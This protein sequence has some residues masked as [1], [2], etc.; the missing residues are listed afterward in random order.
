VDVNQAYEL[1]QYCV[2]KN[3]AQGYLSPQDFNH[4]INVAQRSYIDY[5]IGQYQQYQAKRPI[6]IVAFGENERVRT[7]LA[8][9]IYEVVIPVNSTT[10][11]GAFP[12][13]FIQVDAMWGQYGFYNIRFTEQVRLSANYRSVIDSPISNNDNAVYLIRH[14]G[15]KFFPE[16]IGNA[17]CS[18][19]QN[20]PSISWGYTEVNGIPVWNPATSSNP[21]WDDTDLLNIIVRALA[22]VGVNLQL[23]VVQ[24]YSQTI[25]TQGQ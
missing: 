11:I 12:Y 17:R 18:Y 8:P 7:S 1:C 4:V 5:L 13:G 21:V 3:S 23:N 24:Q 22:I 9:L 14:E 25:K 19:V 10:G 2:A 15:F 16:T 20:P 6:P